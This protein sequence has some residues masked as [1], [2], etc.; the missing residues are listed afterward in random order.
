MIECI[1]ETCLLQVGIIQEKVNRNRDELTKL[2]NVE[3][4][5]KNAINTAADHGYVKQHSSLTDQMEKLLKCHVI[6]T[7]HQT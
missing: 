7:P 5:L 3:P 4:V 2:Q 6:K 1:K